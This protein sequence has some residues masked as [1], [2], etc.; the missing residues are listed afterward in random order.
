MG[1]GY[2]RVQL[3]FSWSTCFQWFWI[4]D[5]A[6]QVAPVVKN[7]PTNAGDTRDVSSVPGSGRHPGEENGTPLQYSFLENSMLRGAWQATVHR[8]AKS[9]TQLSDLALRHGSQMIVV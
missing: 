3:H 5:R 6:S 9:Q 8:V 2:H 7:P 1:T 4:T